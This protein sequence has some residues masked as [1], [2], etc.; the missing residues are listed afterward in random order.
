[1]IWPIVIAAV[2]TLV[3]A[4]SILTSFHTR[5]DLATGRPSYDSLLDYTGI[6]SRHELAR[7]FG[8][9]DADDR[10][11]VTREQAQSKQRLWVQLLDSIAGDTVCILV[12]I[13][14][15]G[16]VWNS[17]SAGLWLLGLA[18]AYQAIGWT[19]ATVMVVRGSKRSAHSG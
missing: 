9:P 19:V 1:M 17:H 2:I 5:R 8:P 16:L 14:A 10:Y 4:A 6:A 12:S 3:A 7:L 18:V 15:L 11:Q 13:L